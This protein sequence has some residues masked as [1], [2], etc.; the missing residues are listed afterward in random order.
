MG[1]R[2]SLHTQSQEGQADELADAEWSGKGFDIHFA[3][4]RMEGALSGFGD[5]ELSIGITPVPEAFDSKGVPMTIR[6]VRRE[7]RVALVAPMR[8]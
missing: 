6:S 4:K 3:S 2:V 7:D 5:D 8:G 1:E